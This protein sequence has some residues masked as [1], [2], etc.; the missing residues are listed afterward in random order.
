MEDADCSFLS[1]R[2]LRCPLLVET[3]LDRN[4]KLSTKMESDDELLGKGQSAKQNAAKNK[5]AN[6]KFAMVCGNPK[7]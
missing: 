5:R 2:P 4:E 7:L 3:N 1:K 6:K